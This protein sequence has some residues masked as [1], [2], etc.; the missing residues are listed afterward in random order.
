MRLRDRRLMDVLPDRAAER[1][2][3]HYTAGLLAL[4][5]AA[6]LC[7]TTGC[8]TRRDR[9]HNNLS[10]WLFRI[11]DGRGSERPFLSSK[12]YYELHAGAL[13]DQ[14]ASVRT[15]ASMQITTSTVAIGVKYV[16][17]VDAYIDDGRDGQLKKAL[18][19]AL[20]EFGDG[21]EMRLHLLKALVQLRMRQ[22]LWAHPEFGA[23][24]DIQPEDPQ[25]GFRGFGLE[26]YRIFASQII[27]EGDTEFAEV[28]QQFRCTW[29][30][31][32]N[33]DPAEFGTP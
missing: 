1:P 19:D 3:R 33:Y 17:V 32:Y 12:D 18:V 5:C 25:K 27:A 14:E 7:G 29:R 23:M 30:E 15:A 31:L 10:G 11:N 26:H 8:A 22:Y 2:L 16:Y 20:R 4:L 24:H 13:L 6:V 28:W 21:R 9:M